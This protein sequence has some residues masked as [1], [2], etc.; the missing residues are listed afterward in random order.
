MITAREI[1]PGKK[2]DHLVVFLHGYG[3]DGNDLIDLGFVWKNKL[4]KVAFLS[5][6]A[7]E[8]CEVNPFGY[9]WFG[10]RDFSPLNIRGGLDKA[11]PELS[12]Y[13]KEKLEK[14]HLSSSELILVGFSQ[15]TMMALEM[16]F[17]FPK[18][19]G[20]LGYS[21]AF[22]PPTAKTLQGNQT[23]VLLI[24]GDLDAVVPVQ[25]SEEAKRQ[26]DMLE[27]ST[28]VHICKGVGHSISEE[29]LE[30]GAKFLGYLTNSLFSVIHL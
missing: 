12:D 17:Y 25:T 18:L 10:L 19:K 3:A 29:G 26:L 16:L 20:I 21:G 22:Y 15:G 27:L 4:S 30:L 28:K 1:I 8:S 7:L 13:L 14:F 6:H 2:V 11:G 23:E 5:P 9:Q 24:H